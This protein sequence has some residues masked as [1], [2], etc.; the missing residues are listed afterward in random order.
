MYMSYQHMMRLSQQHTEAACARMLRDDNVEGTLAQLD[1]QA[2]AADQ[3]DSEVDTAL[4]HKL[5]LLSRDVEQEEVAAAKVCAT[6]GQ[7]A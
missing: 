3:Q 6:C 1:A 5:Q 2:A 4:S 7:R